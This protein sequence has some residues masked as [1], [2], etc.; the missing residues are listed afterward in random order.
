MNF[1]YL[2]T[3]QVGATID[4]ENIGDCCLKAFNDEGMEYIL[5][6]ETQMGVCR[7]FTCG[8]IQV[9][10]DILPKS[11]SISFSRVDF[12]QGMLIKTIE[13]FL[14]NPY[15]KITQAFECT[16][17]EALEDCNDIISYMKQV[18]FW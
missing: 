5:I 18:D 11:T 9:D 15:S 4:V 8:P 7:I 17:E 16:K 6:I 2:V 1:D 14:N 3:C 10:F 12:R 13:G